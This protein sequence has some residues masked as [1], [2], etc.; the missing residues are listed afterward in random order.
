M[1]TASVLLVLVVDGNILRVPSGWRG[2]RVVQGELI[3]VN[4]L[5]IRTGGGRASAERQRR[6]LQLGQEGLSL[7]I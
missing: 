2:R 4:L 6:Q 3:R 7:R 5:R 1:R